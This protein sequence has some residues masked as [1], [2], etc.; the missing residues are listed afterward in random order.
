MVEPPATLPPGSLHSAKIFASQVNAIT[1]GLPKLNCVCFWPW[2]LPS[3]KEKWW[4][5]LVSDDTPFFSFQLCHR[6]RVVA[7]CQ[8]WQ[9]FLFFS[10]LSPKTDKNGSQYTMLSPTSAYRWLRFSLRF[11]CKT[12]SFPFRFSRTVVM[13][14]FCSFYVT[15]KDNKKKGEKKKMDTVARYWVVYYKHILLDLDSQSQQLEYTRSYAA[16]FGMPARPCTSLHLAILQH[17][18]S[19]HLLS[20]SH[21]F[22]LSGPCQYLVTLHSVSPFRSANHTSF[23]Y[24]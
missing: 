6:C 4:M 13:L 3:Q 18:L 12:S 23:F 24:A 5:L 9:P 21:P 16:Y 17:S 11:F 8:R 1:F 19:L 22:T 7:T 10:T 14:L 2:L 15:P 20:T